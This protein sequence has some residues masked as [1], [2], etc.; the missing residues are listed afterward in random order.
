MQT[1]RAKGIAV[2]D[3]HCPSHGKTVPLL[4]LLEL[5]RN[6][7]GIEDRDSD[8]QVREKIT[9]RLLRLERSFENVLPLVFDFLG[10]PDRERLS[11]SMDEPE[12][13]YQPLQAF[14]R[15]LVGGSVDGV[16]QSRIFSTKGPARFRNIPKGPW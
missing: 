16:P 3:A 8:E 6:P 1:C 12:T 4:P 9:G 7:L 13:G 11:S 15:R 10:V 2:F 14:V 5:L